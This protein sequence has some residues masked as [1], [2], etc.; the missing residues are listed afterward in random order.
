MQLTSTY[1]NQ[2]PVL[3]GTPSF[4][5]AALEVRA[6]T[7]SKLT[8]PTGDRS[9]PR[10]LDPDLPRCQSATSVA[11]L[12]SYY[13]LASYSI[14][15]PLQPFDLQRSCPASNMLTVSWTWCNTFKSGVYT[16]SQHSEASLKLLS[17]Q[18]D[19]FIW[20]LFKKTWDGIQTSN[21]AKESPL[22]RCHAATASTV[23]SHQGFFHRHLEW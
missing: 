4:A 10:S 13:T 11:R 8:F 5:A 6:K 17:I 23:L 20:R 22:F 14:C 18:R 21:F 3:H 15:H 9:K 2:P 16:E 7:G 19:F 1:K 12:C